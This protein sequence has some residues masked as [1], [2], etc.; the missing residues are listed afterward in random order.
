[1]KFVV[2]I[3]FLIAML[4]WFIKVP[5]AGMLTGGLSYIICY[6]GLRHVYIRKYS[7]EPTYNRISWFDPDD[8]RRQNWL[9]VVVFVIPL[10]L[11]FIIPLMIVSWKS[12]LLY[13]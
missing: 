5:E 9:D 2:S 8:G 10:L 13:Q 3:T 6:A 7:I 12:K 11:S 4:G 1:M